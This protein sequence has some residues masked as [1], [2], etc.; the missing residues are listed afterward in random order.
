M[1]APGLT[2]EI[3]ELANELVGADPA[4]DQV[5]NGLVAL[6]HTEHGRDR[7]A[8]VLP[9]LAGEVSVFRLLALVLEAKADSKPI[10]TLH[11]TDRHA[12]KAALHSLAA[13]LD[14][15]TDRAAA[16]KAAWH[17]DPA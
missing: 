13:D 4:L 8:A 9:R 6:H 7:L 14:H 5:I 1:G 10:Q 3:H 16:D 11:S 2:S 12:A 15:L 17:L